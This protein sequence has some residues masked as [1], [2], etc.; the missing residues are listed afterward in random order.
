MDI[1]IP[2]RLVPK[3]NKKYILGFCFFLAGKIIIYYSKKQSIVVLF[4]TKTKYYILYKI[5][6][7]TIWLKQILTGI[8]YNIPDTKYILIIRNN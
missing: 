2:I 1:L 5:I 3:K 7:E 4:S 8:K 6:Q